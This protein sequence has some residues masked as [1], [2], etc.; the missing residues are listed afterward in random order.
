[1]RLGG[2]IGMYDVA[3]LDGHAMGHAMLC[4]CCMLADARAGRPAP[5]KGE[6]VSEPIKYRSEGPAQRRDRAELDVTGIP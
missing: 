6:T 5:R 3:D 2:G 1:M 4:L